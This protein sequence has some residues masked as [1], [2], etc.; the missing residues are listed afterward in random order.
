MQIIFGYIQPIFINIS[1]YQMKKYTLFILF[2]TFIYTIWACDACGCGASGYFSG[3][4]PLF[5][6]HAVG[7]RYRYVAFRP[8]SGTQTD[9]DLMQGADIWV[10]A[11][12]SKKIQFMGFLPF[13]SIRHGHNG[14]THTQ[15]GL[16][17]VFALVN[18]NLLNTALDTGICRKTNHSIWIGGGVKAPTGRYLYLEA[19]EYHVNPLFQL[20]TGS[21]DF[22]IQARYLLRKNNMG[23]SADVTYKMNTRNS[24][25]YRFG[26]MTSGALYGFYIHTVNPAL[27][28]MTHVG[29]Y[30]EFIGSSQSAGNKVAETKGGLFAAQAGTELYIANRFSMGVTYQHAVYQNINEGKTEARPRFISQISYMF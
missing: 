5:N 21:T 28:I 12:L 3:I 23:M 14:V 25:Y 30:A 16:G 9:D 29:G 22:L 10:R 18:Y 20:G 19:N 11:Y 1:H 2:S 4:T 7:L 13:S 24:R 17:D 8:E 6:Q 26:N 15:Q 27:S